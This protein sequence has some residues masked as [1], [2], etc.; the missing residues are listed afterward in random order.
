V[1]VACEELAKGGGAGARPAVAAEKGERN[2]T[3]QRPLDSGWMAGLGRQARLRHLVRITSGSSR[4]ARLARL[5]AVT[6]RVLRRRVGVGRGAGAANG[7]SRLCL[8][9]RAH[10]GWR[11]V[12]MVFGLAGTC[13]P[14]SIAFLARRTRG[15]IESNFLPRPFQASRNKARY[16][17][18]VRFNYGRGVP[19]KSETRF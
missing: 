2:A 9:A 17:K 18:S 1:L 8:F 3:R 13:R 14:R 7:R 6:G 5:T 11:M 19:N 12:V 15:T 16:I 4:S 10:C